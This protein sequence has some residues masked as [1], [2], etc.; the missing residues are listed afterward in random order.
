MD[1]LKTSDILLPSLRRKLGV[2]G[3]QLRLARLRRQ[4]SMRQIS[5]R[6][7]ISLSTLEKI[8][9]GSPSVSFGAYAQVLFVL[10]LDADILLLAKDDELGRRIQDMGLSARKRAP[11]KSRQTPNT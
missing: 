1:K 9:K 5:E 7:G 3:G 2:L 4:H 11:K 8:E 10:G 6:A